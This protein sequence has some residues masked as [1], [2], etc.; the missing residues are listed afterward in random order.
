MHD[1][2]R[3]GEKRGPLYHLDHRRPRTRR[4]FLGQGF[5]TGAATVM[6]PTLWGLLRSDAARAQALNCGIGGALQNRIPMI[7]IDLGGG[8]STSGS[9]VMVGTNTQTDGLLSEA[10]Y[11]KLGLP[12]DMTPIADPNVIVG[13][14]TVPPDPTDLGIT[15]HDTSAL[16]DGIRAR[17]SD[18]TLGNTN[19]AVFCAR[20][21]NDTGNNPHNPMY[22]LYH[23]GLDGDVVTL[24][25]SEASDSGG[26]SMAPAGM[27]DPSVRPTKV[28]RPSDA[29]GLVDTGKLVQLLNEDDAAAVMLAVQNISDRKVGAITEDV[30]IEELIQCGYRQTTDLVT[31]FGSPAAFDP[32]ADA[33]INGIF[34][35]GITA[36]SEYRKTASVMKLV[37]NR[38]A[39]AG[40]VQ[41]GGYDYHDSTRATGERKDRIA[42]ECIGAILQYA[43]NRLDGLGQPDPTPIVVYIL[44]DGSVFSDGVLDNSADGGGKGIWR[45]DNSST[46]STIML[47]YDPDGRPTMNPAVGHQVGRF[48]ANGSVDTDATII[49][50][51]VPLLTE[52]IVL[53]YVALHNDVVNFDTY[54]NHSLG[55]DLDSLTAFAPLPR[56]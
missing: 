56:F 34:P 42:G 15:F 31:R 51:E 18:A 19:G 5:L 16:L 32:E 10:G 45:G 25:G 41:F 9:N 43:A 53:N 46:A 44:S 49:A 21:D 20:S 39:G 6:G 28:D 8:A 37:A 13:L 33:V 12:L 36:R 4:E 29:T 23:A 22:G 30:L 52:A 54:L 38:L 35:E 40:T 11:M 55:T 48:K 47:V 27:I 2:D 14:P 24:I 1:R 7:V 3:H 50:G 17:A 26:R